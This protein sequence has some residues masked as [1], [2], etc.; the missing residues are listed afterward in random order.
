MLAVPGATNKQV[1]QHLVA[2][3]FLFSLAR[4]VRKQ[5][6]ASAQILRIMRLYP[7]KLLSETQQVRRCA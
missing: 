7:E 1:K 6:R 5:P 4:V 3:S 2:I